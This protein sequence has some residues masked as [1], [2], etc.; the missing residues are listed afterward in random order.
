MARHDFE[1]RL[2]KHGVCKPVRHDGGGKLGC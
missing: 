1:D 2:D